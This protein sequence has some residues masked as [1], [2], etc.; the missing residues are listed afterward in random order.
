M[1]SKRSRTEISL[2]TK[3]NIICFYDKNK[4]IKKCEIWEK[5]KI[6]PQTLSDI[7][8]KSQTIKDQHEKN[9]IAENIKR[10]KNIKYLQTSKVFIEW[11]SIIRSEHPDLHISGEILR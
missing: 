10:I 7:L 4:S 5:F 6:K 8:S 9:R 3:Y 2:E 11:F 1:T